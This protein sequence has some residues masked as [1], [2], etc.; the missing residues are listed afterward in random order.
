MI[1]DP[2]K[3]IIWNLI[4]AT[5]NY[6]T[7]ASS[8]FSTN[9]GIHFGWLL[10]H[11][12]IINLTIYRS[13]YNSH[14][15]FSRLIS[16]F[17]VR[18]DLFL[19]EFRN[20]KIDSKIMPSHVFCRVSTSSYTIDT[21]IWEKSFLSHPSRNQ[22]KTAN[23]HLSLWIWLRSHLHINVSSHL[24]GRFSMVDLKLFKIQ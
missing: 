24:V 21:R 8:R 11:C 23:N 19:I 4:D 6:T 13:T 9:S 10:S 1:F 20:S 3:L 16:F 18:K 5:V 7:L 14:T 22:R 12:V 15:C 2:V 17:C